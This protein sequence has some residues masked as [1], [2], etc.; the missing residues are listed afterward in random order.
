[1]KVIL[2]ADVKGTG[3]KGEIIEVSEGYAKN[4]LLKKKLADVATESGINEANQK[5]AAQQFHK[6][7]EIKAMKQLADELK[8]KVVTLSL[9]IGEGGRVFG[10][11]T[12]AHVAQSLTDLGFDVDKKKILLD[13]AIK[14]LG[15][16]EVKIRLM[17]N[18]ETKILV[19]VIQA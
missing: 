9:K 18:V 5:K 10:S 4:F 16:Y 6:N 14:T 13:G 17:E 19:K 11:I 2:K 1:M 3:K 7:E 15:D 12:S 8:D